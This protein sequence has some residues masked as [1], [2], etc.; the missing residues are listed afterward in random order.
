VPIPR[1]YGA[2]QWW[3][4]SRKHAEYIVRFHD[5]NPIVREFFRYTMLPDES[6]IQ[7]IL[8]NSEYKNEVINNNLR[9]IDF[10]GGGSHPKILAMEDIGHFDRNDIFFARKFDSHKSSELIQYLIKN[11]L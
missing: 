10:V 5:E 1:V 6:Y 2:S 4:M 9:Y 8:L 11:S 7:S 3:T